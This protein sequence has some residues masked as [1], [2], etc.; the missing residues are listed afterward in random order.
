ML[1]VSVDAVIFVHAAAALPLAIWI[2]LLL[3]RGGFWRVSRALPAQSST[4]AGVGPGGRVGRRVTA[5]VPAR[6]EAASIGR[7]VSSLL[8]QR[9]A[10][11]LHVIVVD[12]GSTD[13]TA[14]KASEAAA[15][16]GASERLTVLRG[17]PP[18]PGWTGKLWAMSQG[19]AAS[20]A[21]T[22][23]FLLLTDADIEYVPGE[24]AALADRADGENLDLVSL[25]VRLATVTFAERCLIP[26]FVFFF[27]KLY[28]P[29]W[30]ASSR[31]SVAGAAGGCMLIRPASLAR[32]GGLAA[33]RGCL[34]DDC[35][36]ARAVKSSG[37]RIRL[38]LARQTRSL[39]VYGSFAEIGAMISRTAFN[40]LRHS[41]PVLTVTL[42]GLVVTYL[43]PPLL[44]LTR[45]PLVM[46][47]GAAAWLLMTLCYL[48]MIRFYRVSVFYA[49][50]LPAVALFY[51]AA[52]VHSAVQYGAGRGGKWKGR[53]QD[54]RSAGEPGM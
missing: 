42:M 47:L 1:Q 24:V 53:A 37:G 25:M 31:S 21:H 30:I 3:A 44:L 54:V 16:A 50:T 17:T 6:N 18:A 5:V 14:E 51:A 49:L 9:L 32:A 46:S 38:G 23:D 33:I 12:D 13:G 22:P 26:A 20:V 52:T 15:A 4:A 39:R 28:P 34:I 8:A 40:Q 43:A 19:V 41:Y 45:E 2:Y 11:P 35:A 29:A 27:L 7:A 48:P 10:P 36:L